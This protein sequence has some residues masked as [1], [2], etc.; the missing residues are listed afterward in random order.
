[1]IES[2]YHF[3]DINRNFVIKQLLIGNSSMKDPIITFKILK[4]I[5]IIIS[6]IAGLL[7]YDN[8]IERNIR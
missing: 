2:L 8:Y 7:V 1:M 5:D 4:V 3:R 6:I